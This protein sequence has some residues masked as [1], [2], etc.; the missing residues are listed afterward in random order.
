[1]CLFARIPLWLIFRSLLE[2][3]VEFFV[4]IIDTLELAYVLHYTTYI[5]ER[6]FCC[7]RSYEVINKQQYGLKQDMEPIIHKVHW[8]FIWFTEY[9]YG[10]M[11]I[12][13]VHWIFIWFNEYSYGLLND[14]YGSLNIHMV[15][16]I[17][18]WFT[19]AD[20]NG[21]GYKL[22]DSLLIRSRYWTYGQLQLQFGCRCFFL[23]LSRAT[24]L[25][26]IRTPTI[27]K[28]W[29]TDKLLT[30]EIWMENSNETTTKHANNKYRGINKPLAI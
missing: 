19:A 3:D 1:M 16:R 2:K 9:S 28:F 13:M 14:S 10:S 30:V 8:I 23:L 11:N 7:V 26:L 5:T 22:T 29:S 21:L 15:H 17:S 20:S 24:P 25:I 6:T 27:Y 4:S 12:H 18:V